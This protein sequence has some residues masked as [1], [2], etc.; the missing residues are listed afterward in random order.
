MIFPESLRGRDWSHQHGCCHRDF[1]RKDLASPSGHSCACNYTLWSWMWVHSWRS[2][3]RV[4]WIKLC[5]NR[6]AWRHFVCGTNLPCAWRDWWRK[7]KACKEVTAVLD[8]WNIAKC[9]RVW[10]RFGNWTNRSEKKS[11]S[12]GRLEKTNIRFVERFTFHARP[13]HGL[14]RREWFSQAFIFEDF[15]VFRYHVCEVCMSSC[16]WFCTA[17]WACNLRTVFPLS[18]RFVSR[19]SGM[20]RKK[21]LLAGLRGEALE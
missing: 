4:T 21:L 13:T 17:A 5:G 11:F 16:F 18:F 1:G 7:W 19:S 10:K 3:H 8:L 14:F 12:F 6:A 9:C 15:Q 2:N 20:K